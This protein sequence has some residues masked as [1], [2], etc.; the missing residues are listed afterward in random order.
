MKIGDVLREW[1]NGTIT[2]REAT[3][4]DVY[5]WEM[6]MDNMP[7]PPETPEERLTRLEGTKADKTDVDE[8]HEALGMIL[9]GV[10]E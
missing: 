1:D 10:T 7:E 9:T 4:E 3:Q 5:R 8:L 2:E 6:E